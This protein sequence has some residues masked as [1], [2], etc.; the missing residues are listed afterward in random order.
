MVSRRSLPIRSWKNAHL[1]GFAFAPIGA[2]HDLSN[3]SLIACDG[4]RPVGFAP[5]GFRPPACPRSLAHESA[6]I[7]V[8]EINHRMMNIGRTEHGQARRLAGPHEHGGPSLVATPLEVRFHF[9]QCFLESVIVLEGATAAG[10]QRQR[11]LL[12]T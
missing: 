3:D 5:T 6:R 7:R 2:A 11:A 10:G 9:S 1:D 4:H 8:V 12:Q